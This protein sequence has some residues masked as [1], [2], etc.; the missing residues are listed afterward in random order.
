MSAMFGGM[1]E[2]P[3]VHSFLACTKWKLA[4]DPFRTSG[5]RLGLGERGGRSTPLRA[6]TPQ[7][8]A[9]LHPGPAQD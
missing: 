4:A 1:A 2:L 7:R 3:R 5:R 6:L 9:Q 8:I